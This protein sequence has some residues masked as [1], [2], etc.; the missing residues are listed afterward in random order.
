MIDG[1]LIIWFAFWVGFHKYV[2]C[3]PLLTLNKH[4]FL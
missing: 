2:P 3:L 4:Q 1:T